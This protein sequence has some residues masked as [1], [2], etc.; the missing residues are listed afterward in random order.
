MIKTADTPYRTDAEYERSLAEFLPAQGPELEKL[1]L[2]H[3]GKFNALIGQFLH[4]EQVSRPELGFAV[5]RLAQFNV[6]P[7]AA[8]FQGLKR[9]AR[10]LATHLHAPIMYPA[11]SIKL[12]QHIR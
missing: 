11:Q 4:V 2:E 8:A 10:Y 6:A 7:N 9:M 1:Q 3:G 12:Y 5:S